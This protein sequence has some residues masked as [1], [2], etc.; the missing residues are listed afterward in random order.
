[1]FSVKI[2]SELLFSN[3]H[4]YLTTNLG[5]SYATLT[6]SDASDRCEELGGF[7]AEVD[8]A[9]EDDTIFSLLNS[10]G[11]VKNYY[12]QNNKLPVDISAAPTTGWELSSI[13]LDL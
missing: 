11:F 3:G 9:E 6:Y 7:L 13:L 2:F 5:E 10:N 12:Y 8:N 4:H 1:M